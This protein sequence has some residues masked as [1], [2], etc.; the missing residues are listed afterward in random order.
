ME[1][2]NFSQQSNVGAE[3]QN[4]LFFHLSHRPLLSGGLSLPDHVL[5]LLNIGFSQYSPESLCVG[6]F[7]YPVMVQECFPSEI[8]FSKKK[9]IQCL[10][11][12][13]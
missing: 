5:S 7:L 8:S 9:K 12:L 10:E 1:K 3:L 11:A 2:A 6:P 4:Q 13:T